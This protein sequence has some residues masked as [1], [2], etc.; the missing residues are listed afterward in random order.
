[1]RAKTRLGSFTSE[2][3]AW[4]EKLQADVD[5]KDLSQ[6]KTD[7]KNAKQALK[8]IRAGIAA[9]LDENEKTLQK[10]NAPNARARHNKFKAELD[11]NLNNF[12]A[13]FDALDE[14]SAVLKDLKGKDISQL[15]TLKAKIAEINNLVNP[16]QADQPL[17]TLPHN[18]VSV[19]P[20]APATGAGISAAYMGSAPDTTASALPVTP[21][22][23]D[24]AE[25]DMKLSLPR[26][27]KTWPKA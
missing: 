25:T 11:S 10:L 16:E 1:M 13:L 14:I 27:S 20:P 26:N 21:T 23:E 5:N 3:T 22:P 2:L 8:D 15:E 9:E 17:G 19:T 6:L 24:L 4:V 18:N 7:I 12:A